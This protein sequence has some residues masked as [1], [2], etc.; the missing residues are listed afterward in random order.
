MVQRPDGD[1]ATLLDQEGTTDAFLIQH[2]Q[3]GKPAA[4]FAVGT[5]SRMDL[6]M[7]EQI[8]RASRQFNELPSG[9][10]PPGVLVEFPID[11]YTL[12]TVYR[13]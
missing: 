6:R 2:R 12:S 4:W 13:K 8:Q 3:D 7:F 10:R 9:E 11:H 5:P 1:L